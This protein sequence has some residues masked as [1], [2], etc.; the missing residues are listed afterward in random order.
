[1]ASS[2]APSTEE[3]HQSPSDLDLVTSLEFLSFM[4][5]DQIIPFKSINDVIIPA[6]LNNLSPVQQLFDTV[7]GDLV[8]INGTFKR[9]KEW[10]DRLNTLTKSLILYDWEGFC[11]AVLKLMPHLH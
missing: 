3:I 2:S 1:M 10:E 6:L 7:Q 11:S 5:I 8:D 4:K 9:L